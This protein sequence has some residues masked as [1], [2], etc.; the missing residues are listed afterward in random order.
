MTICG[1]NSPRMTPG[2][3]FMFHPSESQVVAAIPGS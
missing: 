3:S 1:V 2:L